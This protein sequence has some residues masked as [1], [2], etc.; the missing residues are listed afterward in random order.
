M[1]YMLGTSVNSETFYFSGWVVGTRV[2]NYFYLFIYLFKKK[3]FFF[4]KRTFLFHS[5]GLTLIY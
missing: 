2:F 4:G 3:F 1:K 5:S